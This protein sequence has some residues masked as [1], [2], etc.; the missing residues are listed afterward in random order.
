MNETSAHNSRVRNL[1]YIMN[2][3]IISGVINKMKNASCH[4]ENYLI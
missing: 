2:D 4:L 3:T 1:D